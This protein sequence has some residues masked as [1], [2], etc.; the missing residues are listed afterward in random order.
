MS[1]KGLRASLKYKSKIRKTKL[2]LF[3]MWTPENRARV[4][5]M[6]SQEAGHSLPPPL[7]S[8]DRRTCLLTVL[9]FLCPPHTHTMPLSSGYREAF[10]H[11]GHGAARMRCSGSVW[12][13]I[14]DIR[15]EG[16][17]GPLSLSPGCV[18]FPFRQQLWLHVKSD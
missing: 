17:P 1:V 7:N 12:Q 15:I 9:L 4:A 14:T 18:K 13:S 16:E 5:E 6:T 3:V 8:G 11:L 10:C 2:L